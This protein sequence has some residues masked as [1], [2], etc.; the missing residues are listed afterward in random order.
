MECKKCNAYD[1]E[2]DYLTFVELPNL[3]NRII[4][5]YDYTGRR[6]EEYTSYNVEVL[7]I[8]VLSEIENAK[9]K[10]ENL[11]FKDLPF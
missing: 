11:D 3:I 6:N 8:L 1:E 9:K 7:K 10:I 2:K 4:R 5:L